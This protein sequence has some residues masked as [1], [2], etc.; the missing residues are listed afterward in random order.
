MTPT[1]PN[2]SNVLNALEAANRPLQR[3]DLLVAVFWE[4][5]YNRDT[6]RT[7]HDLPNECL[8]WLR[9]I[10]RMHTDG[11]LVLLP[12]TKWRQILGTAF[13][14]AT[15]HKQRGYFWFATHNQYALWS[16]ADRTRSER[17]LE[18]TARLKTANLPPL[19]LHRTHWA[20]NGGLVDADDPEAVHTSLE[21]LEPDGARVAEVLCNHA[22]DDEQPAHTLAAAQAAADLL[23]NAPADLAFLL[24][25]VNDKTSR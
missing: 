19:E 7:I 8:Q 22:P 14:T 3:Y 13:D 17:I 24:A 10:D 5:G 23:V 1:T 9:F 25:L 11:E 6:Y 21:I 16:S 2:R 18:I 4:I 20:R 12:S 15:I